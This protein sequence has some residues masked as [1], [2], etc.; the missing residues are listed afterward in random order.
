[1]LDTK[2]FLKRFVDFVERKEL[3]FIEG[4]FVV[5]LDEIKKLKIE[6]EK[7]IKLCA[8]CSA[9]DRNK[10]MKIRSCIKE[11]VGS[12]KNLAE[13]LGVRVSDVRYVAVHGRCRRIEL[14]DWFK[15]NCGI[16]LKL[17]NNKKLNRV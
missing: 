11:K 1:M 6:A 13:I 15:K 14:R 7:C 9:V 10:V 12:V 4:N 5:S 3:D 8:S 17:S 16:E 2:K